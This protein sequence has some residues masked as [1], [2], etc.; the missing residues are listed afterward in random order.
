MEGLPEPEVAFDEPLPPG[1]VFKPQAVQAEFP[2]VRASVYREVPRKRIGVK[3]G[4]PG[5]GVEK[6]AVGGL[7]HA[8]RAAFAAV[9]VQAGEGAEHAVAS[10]DPQKPVRSRGQFP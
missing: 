8:A 4:K 9:A 7:P 5:V 2:A 6:G 1:S 10:A 3:R